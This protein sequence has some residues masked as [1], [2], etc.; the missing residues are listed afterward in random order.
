[1]SV[2]GAPAAQKSA[3]SD[4][5]VRR[6]ADLARS[7]LRPD[8]HLDVLNDS[9]D[10]AAVA[11]AGMPGG[12]DPASRANSMNRKQRLAEQAKAKA[13]AKAQQV[14][15]ENDA[16]TGP[17]GSDG[18]VAAWF[19][20]SLRLL[21]SGQWK[22]AL[23]LCDR[24]LERQSRRAEVHCNRGVALSALGRGDDAEKA[25][26]Q[27]IAHNARSAD[28]YNNL[29]ILL[30]DLGRHHEAEPLLRAAIRLRAESPECHINLGVALK[31]LDRL[32]EA[33]AAQRRALAL[34]P[35]RAEAHAN[36]GEV[37]RALGRL[38]QAELALRHA[39]ALRPDYADA[40]YKLGV[41]LRD[42]RR[43]AESEIAC[44]Q[45]IAFEPR[46]AGA[47]SALGNAL[48]ELDRLEEAE[49]AYRQAIALAPNFAEAYNNLGALLK[50]L[51][52][53][54]EARALAE[55]AIRLMPQNGLHR[56]NLSEL[57]RFSADDP[58]LAGM[59]ALARDIAALPLKQQIELN[60]ALA[61]AYEDLGRHHD[62]FA[63]LSTG[64]ALKR[65]EA[66]Y[67]EAAMLRAFDDISR[68]FS[69]ELFARLG[70][71]GDPS[72]KPVFVIGMPRSGTTL[73]EQILASHDEVYGAGEINH[74][75]DA[76]TNVVVPAGTL[77]FPDYVPQLA[78]EIFAEFGARYAAAVAALA[79]QA[80]F[81]V[82]KMPANFF[83]VGLIHLA[84]PNARI[85]H[86]MRDPLD[87]CLSC[88]S[89]LFAAGHEHT[90]DLGELGRYYRAYRGLMAHWHAVLPQGRI[91][92]I[93][94]ED[95][96]ADLEAETARL[97][98]HLGLEFDARCL[99]FHETRR[100]VRTA[101]AT[102]VRRPLYGDSIGRA[103][104][105]LPHL[106]P[107]MAALTGID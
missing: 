95:I 53:F 77:R 72:P 11:A 58:E 30:C 46:H 86:V 22:Q 51:G 27:A 107:L 74:I 60:Y 70:G 7:D 26:R 84:L 9:H 96:V 20:E 2:S 15:L 13:R 64:A 34:D 97:L 103:L 33:E 87:T 32:D 71:S 35:D 47:H 50:H 36:L 91:Y 90:Y 73:V 8:H 98:A 1:M 3:L 57:K 19:T 55:Q 79:P 63:R 99:S 5:H 18:Q 59:E 76:A 69:A 105:F 25:Y 38:E 31:S 37:L 52:R 62:A 68:V 67:D 83:F 43:I 29:G 88:F 66:A 75:G 6:A 104:P 28:A 42:R 40:H 78:P 56:F 49:A 94:Y 41:V 4:R 48:D 101:S 65:N 16:A 45:A 10:S 80:R 93:R 89:K 12:D 61:K 92:D 82:N 102:Q 85:I 100:P 14:S 54:D 24:I 39:I 23:D 44:R 81:I 21:R 17:T 106:E